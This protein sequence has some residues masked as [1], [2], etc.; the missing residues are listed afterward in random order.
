MELVC[1]HFLEPVS[2]RISYYEKA[3]HL[4]ASSIMASEACCTCATIISDYPSTAN[5]ETKNEKQ[6]STPDD[7]RLDCCSRVI[8]G[9]CIHVCVPSVRLRVLVCC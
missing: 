6:F 7:K 9:T 4:C 3:P 5:F 1:L 2:F 8:C